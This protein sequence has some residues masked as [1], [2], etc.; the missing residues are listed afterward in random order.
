MNIFGLLNVQSVSVLA[1]L[2]K[3]S[4][5]ERPM[6][7]PGENHLNPNHGRPRDGWLLNPP[8]PNPHP[9]PHNSKTNKGQ[10]AHQLHRNRFEEIKNKAE[11]DR[12]TRWIWLSMKCVVNF[13][14]K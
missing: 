3:M 2:S 9:F 6:L 13:R 11:R 14:P 8:T 4:K 12:L 1:P 7:C 5:G 10:E